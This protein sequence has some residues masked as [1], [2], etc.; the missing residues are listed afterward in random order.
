M[1]IVVA[2]VLV[3]AAIAVAAVAVFFLL[4]RLTLLFLLLR[5]LLLL[6]YTCHF[7]V[8]KLLDNFLGPWWPSLELNVGVLSMATSRNFL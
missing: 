8:Y 5:L 2:V 1:F 4:L 7:H 6:L 3:V